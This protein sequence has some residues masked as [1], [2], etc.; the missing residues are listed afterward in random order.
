MANKTIGLVVPHAEDKIP[1]EGPK[2][3]PH[4]RFIPKGVGVRSLTPEGYAA[5]FDAIMPA[6]E[7]LTKQNVDAIMVIGTSLTF[8]RGAE[9]HARLLERLRNETGLPVS[10]MSQA[11]LD[12]LRDVGSKRVAVATAYSDIVNQR[13]KELLEADGYEVL[14]LECFNLQE[15]GGPAR[16]SEADIIALSGEAIGKAPGA[17]GLVIS[18]GGLKTLGVGKPLE[19]RHGV[20][21]VSSTPAAFWAAMRLIGE[22]GRVAGHG[23]LLEQ[24]APVH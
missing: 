7:Q 12:G 23:Q 24:G 22:S 2:M 10:T 21:V 17:D 9:A 20:P 15:F 8:Y 16:K 13:L 6:A 5:A 18:C 14:S 4:A 3:Y 11:I 19:D 1:D